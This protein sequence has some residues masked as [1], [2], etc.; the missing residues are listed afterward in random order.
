MFG[1]VIFS[2]LSS[3][4]EWH[5]KTFYNDGLYSVLSK[6]NPLIN[7]I[8]SGYLAYKL[9]SHLLERF[10][11]EINKS[12]FINIIILPLLYVIYILHLGYK[13]SSLGIEDDGA[14]DAIMISTFLVY[15]YLIKTNLNS[16]IEKNK[17][18]YKFRL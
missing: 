11:I 8:L 14:T 17:K 15:I 12:T 16:L 6:I 7:G 4:W 1:D 5:D 13:L 18:E 2:V 10:D 3:F 9:I